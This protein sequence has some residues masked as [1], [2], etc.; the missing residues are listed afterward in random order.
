[1]SLSFKSLLKSSIPVVAIALLAVQAGAQEQ[2][3]PGGGGPGGGTD[4]ERQ[5]RFD[6]FRQQ[7]DTRMK[8]LLR[9]SDE[10]YAVLKPRIEKIQSLNRANDTRRAGFSMLSSNS[11]WRTRGSNPGD[12]QRQPNTQENQDPNRQSRSPF[13]D[14]PTT[15][16]SIKTQEMQAVLEAKDAANDTLKAKLA[17]LRAARKQ[18]K[19][20]MT[21]LQEELRA[22]CSIRQES[23]LVMLGILE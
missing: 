8:E 23:V 9:A 14:T 13:G 15:P 4:A 5:A 22:L 21:Q 6:Q 20:E 7:M 10:E 2:P 19:Q 12:G 17:E 3:R 18:A 16:V 1:M 11:S